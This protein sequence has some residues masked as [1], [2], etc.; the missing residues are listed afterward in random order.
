VSSMKW[1]YHFIDF[2]RKHQTGKPKQHPIGM[3]AVFD[4]VGGTWATH[5]EALF[6]S[7]ADWIS[8]G[9]DPYKDDPRA[10]DGRK[11]I[12]ADVD[13]IWPPAPQRLWFWKCFSRGLNPILMDWYTY[14]DPSRWSRDEQETMRRYMGQTLVL[15]RK[16]NLAA[17][18]PQSK[19]C[20]TGYCLADPGKEY[21]AYLPAGGKVTLDLTAAGGELQTQWLS[22]ASGKW[23]DGERVSGGGKRELTAPFAGDAVLHVAR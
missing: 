15:S 21:V 11:V 8:P 12:V 20:S 10:A 3:T 2:I 18:T 16:L 22:P 9:L 14:G 17:M 23:V 7:A 5:N 19:L 4:I 6:D 13:H 1:Q